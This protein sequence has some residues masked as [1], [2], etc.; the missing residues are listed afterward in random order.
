MCSFKIHLQNLRANCIQET[1]SFPK[2]YASSS[3]PPVPA[4]LHT[5]QVFIS[6]NMS[7]YQSSKPPV[8]DKFECK[9]CVHLKFIF[10]TSGQIAH[11]KRLHFQKFMPSLQNLRYRQICVQ[12]RSSFPKICPITSLPNLW[13][14]QICTQDRS[15]FPKI[16]PILRLQKPPVVPS[17]LHASIQPLCNV[18][19]FWRFQASSKR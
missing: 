9:T 19:P 5:R 3:K 10:K 18:I 16:Y 11:K 4:N 6:K 2:I 15:S 7:Y 17:N 12:D 13:Y 1:S 8:P 14:Q